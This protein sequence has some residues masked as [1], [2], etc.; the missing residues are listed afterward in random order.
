MF[1][2]LYLISKV[3]KTYC[4]YKYISDSAIQSI[5]RETVGEKRKVIFC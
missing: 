4:K 5:A 2:K 3:D 1:A